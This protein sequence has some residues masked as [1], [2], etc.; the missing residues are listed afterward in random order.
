[1]FASASLC[2]RREMMVL[3]KTVPLMLMM[4]MFLLLRLMLS[5]R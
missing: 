1:M 2:A 5:C 4:I 3:M